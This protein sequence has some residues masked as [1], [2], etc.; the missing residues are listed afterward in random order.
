MRLL[1]TDTF[2]LAEFVGE[3]I[4]RYAILS[5]TW[6]GKEVSLHDIQQPNALTY[7]KAEKPPTPAW[8]KVKHACRQA[9]EDGFEFIWIDTCCI[10]KSSSAEL[11]E[12]I[13]SMFAWYRKSALCYAFLSDTQKPTGPCDP[14][15]F[16]IN[17]SR[18]FTRG[19]TLQELLA[20]DFLYFYDASWNPLGSRNAFAKKISTATA[21][22]VNC[23]AG[24]EHGECDIYPS[25]G[26]AFIGIP[27]TRERIEDELQ[28]TTVAARM[29]WAANRQTTRVEDEAY[30]LLGLFGINMPMLYGEGNKAFMRLQ[31]EI[32]KTSDDATILTWGYGMPVDREAY[33]DISHGSAPD[34]HIFRYLLWAQSRKLRFRVPLAASPAD[35]RFAGSLKICQDKD[36]QDLSLEFGISQRGLMLD[37]SFAFDER[38]G[39]QYLL[40]PCTDPNGYLLA[41]PMFELSP[42]VSNSGRSIAN[43]FCAPISMGMVDYG[44]YQHDALHVR[45]WK[46]YLC[47]AFNILPLAAK[48][49]QFLSREPTLGLGFRNKST[50]PNHEDADFILE[51]V[52]PFQS[53]IPFRFVGDISKFSLLGGRRP[54]TPRRQKW[55]LSSSTPCSKNGQVFILNISNKRILLILGTCRGDLI[56]HA[57][58]LNADELL[59]PTWH[60]LDSILENPLSK[61]SRIPY[62]K[63]HLI[64]DSEYFTFDLFSGLELWAGWVDS[65]S[66]PFTRATREPWNSSIVNAYEQNG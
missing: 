16:D 38:H 43:K 48:K 36:G 64:S 34:V 23:L 51:T 60:E 42:S 3:R 20:P 14:A 40:L 61:A 10:D 22:P 41:L 19:W 50:L 27:R 17:S 33:M 24:P 53:R 6:E 57:A 49:D 12:A 39:L 46:S 37:G 59:R 28:N 65:Q 44:L 52:F 8:S 31:Q 63:H 45:R 9:R 55:S 35:Y 13:N 26:G 21:I 58:N 4:P 29:S 1:K 5:H 47:G 18:W 62:S 66:N 32:M 56:C 11:Q 15:S 7:L 30:C 2:E 54:G 25:D